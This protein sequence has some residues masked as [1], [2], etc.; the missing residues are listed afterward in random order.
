[1]ARWHHASRAVAIGIYAT[2]GG[3]G[4][5]TT[6]SLNP[7]SRGTGSECE[8]ALKGRAATV[9]GVKVIKRNANGNRQPR[10][11]R[12]RSTNALRLDQTIKAGVQLRLNPLPALRRG[13]ENRSSDLAT[14][15][16]REDPESPWI[17]SATAAP[18]ASARTNGRIG[19]L[20]ALFASAT[21]VLSHPMRI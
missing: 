18:S 6:P 16:D 17:R 8:V 11:T 3:A 2:A 13:I 7:V 19:V 1:M 10:A 4:A 12:T 20:K 9:R 21:V 14:P 5:A 15:S